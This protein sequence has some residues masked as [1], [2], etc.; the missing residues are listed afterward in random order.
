MP[1]NRTSVRLRDNQLV[2]PI[3]LLVALLMV[4]SALVVLLPANASLSARIV[5]PSTTM[6]G[7]STMSGK[8]IV[9]NDTGRALH[10]DGCLTPFLV[11]LGN[12]RIVP[13]WSTPLC[14]QHFTI[15]VGESSWP[16]TVHGSL[17]M[18]SGDGPDGEIPG[19]LPDGNTPPLPPGS[20]RAMLLQD[21][22]FVPTP[23]AISIRV[24][25]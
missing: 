18:C 13:N 14:L 8:V 5:L 2:A 25:P 1:E 19:C 22:H 20:Y 3:A 12:D 11:E 15:P 10:G 16:V 9:T 21:P 4:L 7:G 24:T 23:S 17:S 6:A